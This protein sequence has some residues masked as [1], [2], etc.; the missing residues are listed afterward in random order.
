MGRILLVQDEL[1]HGRHVALKLL[2]RDVL[3]PDWVALLKTEFRALA[4][5]RHPGLV[6]VYD[7]GT[8]RA[9]DL[10]YY[11]MEALRGWSLLQA[12]QAQDH[13]GLVEVLGQVLRALAFIH[14][15]G[16]IH[17]DLKPSNV[18]VTEAGQA[19]LMDFALT[20]TAG[21]SEMHKGTP[22]YAAPEMIRLEPVDRRLDLYSLGATL[23]HVLA[24]RT[25]FRGTLRE[26]LR[27]HLYRLPPPLALEGACSY[28]EPFVFRLLAKRPE[29]R[30]Y[31]AEHALSELAALSRHH[32][33]VAASEE[34]YL[35]TAH[36]VGRDG[37]LAR[38]R[39]PLDGLQAAP[40]AGG[41]AVLV[42]VSGDSGLG[43]SRLL[44]EVEVDVQLRGLPL[45]RGHCVARGVLPLQ[46]LREAL[47]H[48]VLDAARRFP[49]LLEEHRPALARLLPGLPALVGT[50]VPV[51]EG[52]PETA[53]PEEL[54]RFV[55]AYAERQPLVLHLGDLQWADE[56]TAETIELL[57]R[58]VQRSPDT[59]RLLLYA[60]YRPSDSRG[61]PWRPVLGRLAGAPGVELLELD[62]LGPEGVTRMLASM[63]GTSAV[64]PAVASAVALRT[65]GH[66]LFVEETV[67]YL[68]DWG[69]LL[70]RGGRIELA[71]DLEDLPMPTSVAQALSIA[72]DGLEQAEVELVQALAVLGRPAAAEPLSAVLEAPVE[73]VARRARGL[74]PRHFLNRSWTEREY[75]YSLRHDQFGQYLYER[76]SPVA[77]A[78]LHA[79]VA[80]VLDAA[81]AG[82][83]D[84]AAA[85]ELAVH[86]S[87][88]LGARTTDEGYRER[89]Y[90]A[91][92]E[93]A[94]LAE[95]FA[96]L[97]KRVELVGR[98]QRVAL[99]GGERYMRKLLEVT[100]RLLP[101]LERMRDDERHRRE[102]ARAERLERLLEALA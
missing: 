88:G 19:K 12:P 50:A 46:A 34:S 27:D 2:R 102:R 37:E 30:F 73:E 1:E 55:T 72:F 15:A 52:K 75:L 32:V 21:R 58:S 22:A 79:K 25:P 6:E 96:S 51:L 69:L 100:L 39:R 20:G 85:I 24:G 35:L 64:E 9:S 36:V 16:F 3:R 98:A 93:A 49:D 47:R 23:Y 91:C 95:T 10:P 99:R 90:R 11:T 87:E 17:Y 65:G 71:G 80:E 81:V 76:L 63:L 70:R 45:G 84:P 97:P 66:P 82:A 94:E 54:S 18:F 5:L 8:D 33:S 89:A 83:T 41:R 29:D 7:F 28:L 13:A 42:L 40:P 68:L 67:R 14:A 48:C 61:Q 92:L 86:Y 77:K 101:L 26:V 31:S 62:P 59:V 43:K 38:L 74:L 57:T 53:L 56:P 44:H 60:S 78:R 4:Q